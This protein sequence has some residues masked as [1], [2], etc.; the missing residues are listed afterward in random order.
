MTQAGFHVTHISPFSKGLPL[1]EE[2]DNVSFVRIRH[3]PFDGLRFILKTGFAFLYRLPAI[4]SWTD[5]VSRWV[6]KSGEK[7]DLAVGHSSETIF[8]LRKTARHLKIPAVSRLYGISATPE[9]LSQEMRRELYFD[10][11]SLFRNPPDHLIITD[12]GTCG[13]AICRR[14]RIPEN[15]YDFLVNGYEPSIFKAKHS[16]KSSP[17]VLTAARLV[18]W[19]RIDRVIRI[20]A[21]VSQNLPE[22]QFIVL[23][24]GPE[25]DSLVK[26]AQKLG[27]SS[28]VKFM[29][30]VTRSKMHEYLRGAAIVLST[31]ELS[32]LTNT[33]LEALVLGKPVVTLDTGCVAKFLRHDKT[34]LLFPPG[35]IKGAAQGIEKIMSDDEFRNRLGSKARSLSM[36]ILKPWPE[37]IRE[38]AS[39]YERYKLTIRR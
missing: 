27:V 6:V 3:N 12:D 4:V 16:S 5:H 36:K 22:L 19:K 2:R 1:L 9:R 34:A 28:G 17:Y 37:R 33:V 21:Y 39:I 20:A 25:R 24:D 32:N 10:L 14:F 13:D 35:D 11:I 38:E 23:G 29:G 18:D 31:Q 15:R 7:F 8:A 26:L 30:S